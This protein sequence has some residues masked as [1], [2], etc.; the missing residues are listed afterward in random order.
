MIGIYKITN[1]ING[2]KYIGQSKNIERRFKDHKLYKRER[3]IP[4]KRALEK[5]GVVNFN[6]EVIELCQL[7]ELDEKE[8]YWIAKE[9]PE[10]N[11]CE[12][13][14]GNKGH[15]VSEETKKILSQKNK[16]YWENLPKDKK[17]KIIENQLIGVAK[18]HK[19]SEETKIKLRN[20]NLGKKQSIETIEKRK[21]TIKL[22]KE[23]GYMQTNEN[24]KKS[25]MCI[26]TSEIFDSLKSAQESHN[27]TT[28]CGH[29]KGKYKTCKGKHYMYINDN[30]VTTNSDECKRVE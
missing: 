12:G 23:N 7:E 28:L 8:V 16:I 2:K 13:G 5:Y 9:K 19:V 29:L 4:L 25:I 26:E 15:K 10:Y 27:L 1:K 30:S 17:L 22:K 14:K 20:C 21:K 18:G 24:H 6:Y 3:N 11:L